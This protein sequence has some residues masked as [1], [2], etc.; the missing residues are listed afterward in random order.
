[1]KKAKKRFVLGRECGVLVVTDLETGGSRMLGDE[2]RQILVNY[3]QN[4]DMRS[5]LE[6]KLRLNNGLAQSM[7]GRV[8]NPE[9]MFTRLT[10]Q[11]N[12]ARFWN[13]S[14]ALQ[15]ARAY[16]AGQFRERSGIPY[17]V[18]PLRMACSLMMK[19]S[20]P[21]D[22][23]ISDDLIAATLLHDVYEDAKVSPEALGYPEGVWKTVDLVS[24]E[25]EDGECDFE[26]KVA[27]YDR[28]FGA[29][30]KEPVILKLEDKLD[31]LYTMSIDFEDDPDR[32]RKNVVELDMLFL[33]GVRRVRKKWPEA[34]DLIQG[35]TWAVTRRVDDMAIRYGVL[36]TDP[37]FIN[38]FD[39]RDYSY[40]L[41]GVMN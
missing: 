24:I 36:R 29:G 40:L 37:N 12:A 22:P 11:L 39:A 4:L 15:H 31:S 23:N 27:Y 10:G 13:A 19:W 9:K 26:T 5:E 3:Q 28:L 16:H 35:L 41:T 7:I 8:D 38:S 14:R 21:D 34:T 2:A 25:P 18:H 17:I 32:C 6:E 20:G 1:M 33:P 30:K